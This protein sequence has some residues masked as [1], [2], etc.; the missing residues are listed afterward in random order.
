MTFRLGYAPQDFLVLLTPGADFVASLR[1]TDE[2]PWP[3]GLVLTIDLGGPHQWV[4]EL[5]GQEA[6]WDVDAEA[7][8]AA[9]AASPSKAR[10]W[11][12]QG[13]TRL[14]WATGRVSTRP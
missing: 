3:D 5:A 9:L 12:T 14:L 11:Y 10:L 6:S 4:A 2:E 7:V 8:D 13:D 1:R